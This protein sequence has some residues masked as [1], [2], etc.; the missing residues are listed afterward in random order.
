MFASE[1]DKEEISL[2]VLPLI[3]ES[4]LKVLKYIKSYCKI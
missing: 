4:D 3:C 2:D 1:L